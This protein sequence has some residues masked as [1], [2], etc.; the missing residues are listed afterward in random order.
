[1]RYVELMKA[2]LEYKALY[3]RTKPGID[4][5]KRQESAII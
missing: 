1:M 4:I 3:Y 2:E 5:I